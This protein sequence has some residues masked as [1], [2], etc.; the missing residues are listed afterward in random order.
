MKY[1]Y[2]G[3]CVFALPA[4][5]RLA[6]DVT[7]TLTSHQES[8]QTAL[9]RQGGEIKDVRRDPAT[10]IQ[11]S[12]AGKDAS[13]QA[14]TAGTENAKTSR[15]MDG[16]STGTAEQPASENRV[17]ALETCLPCDIVPASMRR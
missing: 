16:I 6:S 2:W 10:R 12:A 1:L 4:T 8:S 15:A 7:H 17:S 9:V 11:N 13:V 5:I 14:I 3:L